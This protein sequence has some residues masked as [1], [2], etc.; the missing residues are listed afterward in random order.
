[1]EKKISEQIK[2][3]LDFV[4]EC[5]EPNSMAYDGIRQ[6]RVYKDMYGVTFPVIEFAQEPHNQKALD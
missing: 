2:G 5:R 1:M 6:R 4:D 3:F